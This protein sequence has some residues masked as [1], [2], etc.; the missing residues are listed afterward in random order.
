M[1][2]FDAS[3]MIH[4]WYNYPIDNFPPLWDWFEEQ[5]EGGEFS[6]PRVALDEV[7]KKSPDCGD[8]LKKR[9]IEIL[10]LSNEVLQEAASM[11]GLLGIAED[12]Y[13]PKGV[14]ENDLLIVATA[15]AAGLQLVSDEGRQAKLPDS[16]PKYKIPAV[17]SQLE[18][19]VTCIQF[20]ELIRDSGAVFR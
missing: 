2:T 14:G 5:I 11:K 20:I 19:G 7:A 18:V 3:S 17:C 15:K 13:H 4:A 6:I 12:D 10:P 8:W 9:G 16:M 1:Y